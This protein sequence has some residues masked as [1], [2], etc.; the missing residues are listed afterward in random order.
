MFNFD[1]PL[2]IVKRIIPLLLVLFLAGLS[3]S[4]ASVVTNLLALQAITGTTNLAANISGASVPARIY[5]VQ[6]LGLATTNAE[7]VYAQVSLD[8]TNF[9]TF[10][11]FHH[12]TT[13]SAVDTFTANPN[14]LTLYFR[15]SVVTTNAVTVGV[16]ELK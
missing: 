13:N 5:F 10:A 8:N 14:P 15:A 1:Y 2:L 6:N 3:L 12:G 7:V 4:G 11:T 9:V 16:S